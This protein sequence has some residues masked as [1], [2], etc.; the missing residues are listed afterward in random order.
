MRTDVN[1]NIIFWPTID[2]YLLVER[3][4]NIITVI[5]IDGKPIIVCIELG[6]YCGP[7]FNGL[8]IMEN[9]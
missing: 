7:D 9:Y 8:W 3:G 5:E 4:N 2:F 6:T 1:W